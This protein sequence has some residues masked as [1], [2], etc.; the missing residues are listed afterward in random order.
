MTPTAL[1]TQESPAGT[2]LRVACHRFHIP[3]DM[4]AAMIS[5]MTVDGEHNSCLHTNHA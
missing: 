4:P 3:N 2:S 5:D 1:T